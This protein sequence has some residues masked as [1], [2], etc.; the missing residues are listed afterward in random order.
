MKRL[1]VVKDFFIRK[2]EESRLVS[3]LSFL[4]T[5]NIVLFIIVVVINVLLNT[6]NNFYLVYYST[7]LILGYYMFHLR[8]YVDSELTKIEEEIPRVVELYKIDKEKARKYVIGKTENEAIKQLT[9]FM[10]T[11]MVLLG[12]L[13]GLFSI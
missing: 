7:P 5:V 10:I 4:F 12:I 9:K 2:R 1:E 6:W 11:F 13:I 3:Q 8:N